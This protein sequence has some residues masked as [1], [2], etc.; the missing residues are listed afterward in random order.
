MQKKSCQCSCCSPCNTAVS[1]AAIL[2]AVLSSDETPMEKWDTLKRL[3]LIHRLVATL[4]VVVAS[5]QP[6]SL[7]P[8]GSQTAALSAGRG[9][10]PA[11]P[12]EPGGQPGERDY[13][14]EHG[15]A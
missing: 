7:H 10:L 8:Q 11:I 9:V 1:V 13:C 2:H 5:L 14:N 15:V 3:Q 12:P 4:V 6:Q